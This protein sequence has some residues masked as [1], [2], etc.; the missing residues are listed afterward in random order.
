MISDV[1]ALHVGTLEPI[2][3]DYVVFGTN[4]YNP[5]KALL[6]HAVGCSDVDEKLKQ[7]ETIRGQLQKRPRRYGWWLL[8][9]NP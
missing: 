2:P 9:K 4:I 6:H 8:G 3:N 7:I 1:G 5:S